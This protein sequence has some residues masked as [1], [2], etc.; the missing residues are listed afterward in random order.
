[1]KIEY[2]KQKRLAEAVGVTPGALNDYLAG[3][4][5][6]SAVIARKLGNE[7][8]VNPFIWMQ[9]DSF[10]DHRLN[11]VYRQEAVASWEPPAAPAETAA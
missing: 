11:V 10:D 7:T 2:G 5:N 9:A 1:M 8:G 4:C 6:A 3:R